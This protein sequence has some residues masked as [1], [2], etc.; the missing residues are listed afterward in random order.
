MVFAR[1]HLARLFQGAKALDLDVSATRE[2][3]LQMVYQVADANGM[4]ARRTHCAR[5]PR[6]FTT[7][8]CALSSGRGSTDSLRVVSGGSGG[9]GWLQDGV[10][11]RLM[12]TRG[13]KATP[14]QSP[15]VN[16]GK[17]RVL[18]RLVAASAGAAGHYRLHAIFKLSI[19]SPD[20]CWSD[21][22]PPTYRCLHTHRLRSW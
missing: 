3:V 21:T 17:A 13:L 1:E 9:C 10:H 2:E 4:T 15:K 16:V 22:A 8:C 6:L 12:V 14:Y 7:A 20:P 18:L 11:I 19:R 5:A